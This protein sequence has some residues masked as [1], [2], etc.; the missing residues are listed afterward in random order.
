MIQEANAA[1]EVELLRQELPAASWPLTSEFE[2]QLQSVRPMVHLDDGRVIIGVGQPWSGYK[3]YIATI[4][5]IS[6]LD[7]VSFTGVSPDGRYIALVDKHSIRV[8]EGR[9]LAGTVVSS[10]TWTEILSQIAAEAEG[11]QTLADESSPELHLIEVIPFGEEHRVLLVT[12]YGVYL[13][14]HGQVEFVE[15]D[16]PSLRKHELEDTRIDMGHGS[17]SPDGQW[18]ACGSQGSDHVLMHVESGTRYEIPPEISYPHYSI[19]TRDGKQVWYNACHFYNG[20]TVAV[21]VPEKAGAD[22][23]LEQ[24]EWP[25][26]DESM[27]A[28]AGVALEEGII[29]GDAYGY[30]RLLD[31]D[32]QEKWRHFVGST[33]AGLLVS[34]DET[35]LYVGTYGGMLHVLDLQSQTATDYDI[36]TAPLRENGRWIL[37]KDY[38]PLRW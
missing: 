7:H 38:E 4:E 11:L 26:V 3:I 31:Q 6:E 18:I 19:F 21:T 23:G 9:D 13:V 35:Q 33:I 8:I 28:Y 30:L 27:R 12:M 37:W 15:P 36:G 2:Q 32:G 14:K 22:T 24:Q 5:E 17:V 10:Y 20:A 34:P 29:L 1:G 25:F 16:I